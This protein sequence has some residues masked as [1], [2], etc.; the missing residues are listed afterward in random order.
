[1]TCVVPRVN[2][3]ERQLLDRRGADVPVAVSVNAQQFTTLAAPRRSSSWRSVRL[4][5]GT[6]HVT[7]PK[8]ELGAAA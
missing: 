2:L 7:A 3:T 1:M 5:L 8:V 4:T 6:T